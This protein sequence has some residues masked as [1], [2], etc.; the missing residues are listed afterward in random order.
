MSPNLIA[1]F[2]SVIVI[3]ITV[4]G[5]WINSRNDR[6]VT[7][8]ELDILEKLDSNGVAARELSEVIEFRIA[9]WH[10]RTTSKS[11]RR[12]R[13]VIVVLAVGWILLLLTL[14]LLYQPA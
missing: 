13:R 3:V 9:K 8:Q 14:I 12:L 5:Q 7:N 1:A 2:A 10:Q 4:I 6:A 11:A